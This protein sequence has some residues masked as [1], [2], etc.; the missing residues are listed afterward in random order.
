MNI[1]HT[2]LSLSLLLLPGLAFA[3]GAKGVS[4]LSPKAGAEVTS[5]VKFQ[6]SA[7]GMEVR[8]AGE[9]VASTGHHHIL[10]DRG[11]VPEGQIIGMDEGVHHFG[12]GQTE[13]EFPLAEGTHTVSLQFAN[14]AHISYG[15]A[16]CTTITI[17]VK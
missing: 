6:M 2:V 1:N 4:F 9:V 16:M 7:S 15:P 10:F 8:P 12:K 3:D 17:R 13:A 11:C 5:P 14:G